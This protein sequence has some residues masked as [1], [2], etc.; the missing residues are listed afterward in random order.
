MLKI[1]AMFSSLWP[2]VLLPFRFLL[3]LM[4]CGS[5]SSAFFPSSVW[6]DI[7]ATWGYFLPDL[8]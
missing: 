5:S 4:L 7:G 6:R 3:F 2:L 1:R 8:T